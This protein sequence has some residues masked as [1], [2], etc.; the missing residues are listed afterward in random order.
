MRSELPALSRLPCK[1]PLPPNHPVSPSCAC[2]LLTCYNRALSF[3]VIWP[4]PMYASGYIFSKRF[5]TGWVSV[6]IAWIFCSFVAVGLYPA[7]ES[8]ATLIKVTRAMLSG[9]RIKPVSII[10]ESSGTVTP[11]KSEEP[12]KQG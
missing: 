10:E 11:V 7:W 12:T 6:G 8:R 1:F 2:F 4:M 3:L 9:G 5:F